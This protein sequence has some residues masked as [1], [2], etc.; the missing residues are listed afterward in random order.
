MTEHTLDPR[1]IQFCER[2]EELT[3]GERAQLR[4]A[5]GRTMAEARDTLALFYRLLSPGVPKRHESLYF[6]VATL[7]PLTPQADSGNLGQALRSARTDHNE[8]GLDRRMQVLLDADESQ[9]PFR[10]RQ[11][12]RMLA[13][14]RVGLDWALLLHDLLFWGHGERFVQRQWAR[15]YFTQTED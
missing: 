4:R 10:L 7:F 5:S 8:R 2:L 3:T 6:V 1:I 11:A 13:S 9:L 12:V 15:S 14:N